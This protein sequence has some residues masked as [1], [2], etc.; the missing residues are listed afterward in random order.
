MNKKTLYI[1][2]Q[3]LKKQKVETIYINYVK[4]TLKEDQPSLRATKMVLN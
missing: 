4:T 3:R 2:Q 1:K